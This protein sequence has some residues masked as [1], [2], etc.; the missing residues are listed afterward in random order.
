MGEG[1][2]TGIS[3]SNAMPHLATRHDVMPCEE[4]SSGDSSERGLAQPETQR[5]EPDTGTPRSPRKGAK[6]VAAAALAA[7]LA[8][9]VGF[10]VFGD[11]VG[12][13]TEQ[14]EV[15]SADAIVVLTGGYQRLETALRLLKMKRGRRLLISGVHPSIKRAELRRVTHADPKLFECCVD[16]DRAARDTI[17]NATESAKWIRAKGYRRVILVTNNYHMPRSLVEMRRAASGVTFIPYP[18]VTADLHDNRWMFRPKALRVL[19]IEYVKYLA[20]I[21]RGLLPS[22]MSSAS[23][24]AWEWMSGHK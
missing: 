24:H 19:F 1:G 18:V 11:R 7:V 23:A 14:P 8:F 16:L 12:R 20:A 4:T 5:T 15:K 2:E 22:G 9:V 17:S 10:V 3:T 6:L 21:T 13:M